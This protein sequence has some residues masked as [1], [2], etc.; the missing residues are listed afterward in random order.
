MPP[1]NVLLVDG[2]A[3]TLDALAFF[4]DITEDLHPIGRAVTGDEA[5]RLCASLQPDVVLTEMKFPETDAA[6]LIREI[7]ARHP[8]IGVVVLTR[9][10]QNHNEEAIRAGASAYLKKSATIDQIADAIRS[11]VKAPHVDE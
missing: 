4:L 10:L 3:R 9:S 2:D 1:I 6:A 8:N 11:A 5:L 7:H